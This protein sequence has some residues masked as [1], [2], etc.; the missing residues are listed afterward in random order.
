MTLDALMCE[1]ARTDGH[2]E[3]LT[4][5]IRDVIGEG[6]GSALPASLRL[7]AAL[8]EYAAYDLARGLPSDKVAQLVLLSAELDRV[9]AGYD[10]EVSASDDFGQNPQNRD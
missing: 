10:S 4:T 2:R 5:S 3:K 6:K 9:A 7:A 8:V 1:A